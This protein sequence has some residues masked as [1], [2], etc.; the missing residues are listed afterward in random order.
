MFSQSEDDNTTIRKIIFITL[1][2]VVL[3]SFICYPLITT[4]VSAVKTGPRSFG[5]IVHSLQD[6]AKRLNVS[7]I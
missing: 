7:I 4:N 5:P 2:T 3:N 6:A 1:D